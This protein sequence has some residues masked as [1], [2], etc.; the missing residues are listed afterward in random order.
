MAT[1][2][3]ELFVN[4]SSLTI[5]FC[6]YGDDSYHLELRNF[7]ADYLKAEMAFFRQ[8][9]SDPHGPEH[10]L[11]EIRKDGVW[12][13]DLE[14]Q[15]IS[16]LYDCRL[17]IYSTS[18]KP[19]KMFNDKPQ[20]FNIPFRL[21]YVQKCHYDVIWDPKRLH[22]LKNHKFGEFETEALQAAQHRDPHQKNHTNEKNY[23]HSPNSSP[24]R[25]SRSMFEKQSKQITKLSEEK[26]H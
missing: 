14:I 7:V 20:A 21:F 23:T 13:D 4:K 25:E 3:I 6:L 16:E 18:N 11:R 5:V 2:C 19:I 24:S 17:E 12:A 9:I 26:S 15:I 8:F 1:V 10:Y 22:P